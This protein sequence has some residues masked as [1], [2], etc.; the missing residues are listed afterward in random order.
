MNRKL[1]SC[2]LL[3]FGLLVFLF[4]P[5]AASAND[6][7]WNLSDVTFTDG[8]TATGSFVYN[9]DTNTV[10][11]IDIITTFGAAFGGAD[12]TAVDPGYAPFSSGMSDFVVVPNAPL[13]D[14]TGTPALDLI[15]T[16]LLTDA[17]GTV[18][19]D[20]GTSELT[21]DATCGSEGPAF[22]RSISAGEVTTLLV[23]T[24]E[25]SAILLL[26]LGLIGLCIVAK[27]KAFR[28]RRVAA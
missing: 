2:L 13:T 26:G 12:Y 19:L 20:P 22:Y 6:V 1:L 21:C 4:L 8:G 7:T 15:F 5:R 16:S 25:P 28:D 23:S 11:S 9:A 10:S 14:F 18:S 27:R 3:T 17:G 24:P